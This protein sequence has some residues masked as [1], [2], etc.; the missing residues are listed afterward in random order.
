MTARNYVVA[1]W[2]EYVEEYQP[3]D[4]VWDLKNLNDEEFVK[5]YF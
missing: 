4:S 2:F 3:P 1:V 5:D